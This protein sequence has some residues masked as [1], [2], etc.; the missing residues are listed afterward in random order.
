MHKKGTFHGTFKDA[1]DNTCLKYSKSKLESKIPLHWGLRLLPSDLKHFKF[2]AYVAVFWKFQLQ[3]FKNVITKSKKQRTACLV[4]KNFKFSNILREIYFDQ[5]LLAGVSELCL[6][7]LV[8]SLNFISYPNL[9]TKA[10][11]YLIFLILTIS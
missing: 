8:S 1:L 9:A 4:R 11:T 2:E 3:N 6:F 5:N 7:H 10:S